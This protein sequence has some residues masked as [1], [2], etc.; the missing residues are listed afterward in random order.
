M[1]EVECRQGRPYRVSW[2]AM[3]GHSTD[4]G[5]KGVRPNEG[6]T[7]EG[8]GGATPPGVSLDKLGR[9][10][11]CKQAHLRTI[12]RRKSGARGGSG[13]TSAARRH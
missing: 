12:P 13:T 10:R 11:A 5:V 8:R 9:R 3:A 4:T 6:L 1:T 7:R 2:C